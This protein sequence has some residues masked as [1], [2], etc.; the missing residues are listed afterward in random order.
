MENESLKV[1]GA[2]TLELRDAS[3]AL[4]DRREVK[5]TVTTV[6]KTALATWLAAATQSATFMPYVALGTGTNA[7]STG[8]TTLQTELSTR[9]AGTITSSTNVFQSVATFGA[10]TDTGAVT[11]AG[12]MSAS[13]SGTLFARQVFSVINKGASDS[14]TVTWQVTFS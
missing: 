2:F 5:N 13:S 12:L 6:G 1:T 8:D 11:E 14:L 9:V 7:A 4:K 10:G 3:G